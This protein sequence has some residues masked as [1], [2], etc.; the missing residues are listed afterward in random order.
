[1][2]TKKRTV[3]TVRSHLLDKSERILK[4]FFKD[5]PVSDMIQPRLLNFYSAV[6]SRI[7]VIDV[8]AK[9]RTNPKSYYFTRM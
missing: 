9:F 5:T 2:A 3:L 8:A 7:V 6:S 4:M 1:M